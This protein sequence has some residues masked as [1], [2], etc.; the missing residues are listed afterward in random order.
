M[1]AAARQVLQAP[2]E[3][4]RKTNSKGEHPTSAETNATAGNAQSDAVA[5]QKPRVFVAAENRLLREALCRMLTK[6]G[7]SEVVGTDLAELF[8]TEGLFKDEPDILL[9]AARG[10]R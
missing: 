3:A 1:I 9:L 8:R 5:A 7:E 10:T 4:R 6:G 2:Q